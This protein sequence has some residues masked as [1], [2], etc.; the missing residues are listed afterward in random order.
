MS[1]VPTRSRF[2]APSPAVLDIFVIWHPEDVMGA[3]ICDTLF[4]HYHSDF[5]SGL[6]GSAV[7][8]YGRSIPLP[9]AGESP[10]PII[11]TDGVV[12]D[13][14]LAN[15]SQ[16]APFSSILPVIG[17]NLIQASLKE[18]SPWQKYLNS[19]LLLRESTHNNASHVLILPVL[20]TNRLDFS[21]APIITRLMERQGLIEDHVSQLYE[22]THPH[23]PAAHGRL[24]RDLNQAVIQ[25]LLHEPGEPDRFTIFV[26]HSRTE[27]S[28]ADNVDIFPLGPVAKIQALAAK[29]RLSTFIDVH[30]LQ[31]GKDWDEEIRKR[32]RQSAL[33]MVRTDL[34]S[35]REW[36]QWEVLEAKKAGMPVVC[37]NSLTLGEQRGSFLMDHV[38]TVAYPAPP[39]SANSR[40]SSTEECIDGRTSVD[41]REQEAIVVALNRLVDESLKR[42]L[43]RHQD[44]PRDVDR[45][46]GSSR[47]VSSSNTT[48]ID[49]F[50][51]APVHAPEP[52]ML[53]RFLTDHKKKFPGDTH[54]W[55]IHP[56]P[57]LLPPEHEIMVDLCELSGYERNHIHLL[58][59]RTFF[60]AGGIYGAGEPT[61]STPN[62]ILQRPLGDQMLGISMALCEDLQ[63]I[64]LQNKHLE[65]A[66]AEVAQMV[67]LAGGGITYAGAIGTHAPDL[68]NAVIGTVQRY[69]ETAKLTQHRQC[70]THVDKMRQ[71][72][73]GQMFK[74]TVP[75]TSI[76][77]QENINRLKKTAREF[78]STGKIGVLTETGDLRNLADAK[79]WVTPEATARAL[80]EIRKMLPTHCTARLVIGGK[81]I[82]ASTTASNGYLGN[83]PGIIEEA[84]YSV[85]AGQ[86]LFIAGG[87]GGAAAILAHELGLGDRIPVFLESVAA[88]NSHPIY[89]TAMDEIKERYDRS[90]TGLDDEELARLTTTQRASELA[91]LV[92]RGLSTY[93]SPDL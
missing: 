58:T 78:A 54:L 66:I 34:Y 89:R 13:E 5:F 86:P 21:N 10:P 37:L 75:C 4:E 12:G 19:L 25:D 65:L 41:R 26:S 1:P 60:A 82:P 29:T 69:I 80:T 84:L 20:P 16:P 9:G 85:R 40:K 72:H 23:S 76:R 27:I 32:A 45:R 83:Y 48:N 74:L 11:T 2:S 63:A 14:S 88:I 93:H 17:E 67:L 52:L 70:G 3:T 59:P 36:T 91:G 71:L 7:E 77:T 31:A 35:S 68:T 64:G 73:P 62:L 56:D 44:I 6:A 51:A 30:D 42:S 18:N 49:G 61:L 24:T 22:P 55:L 90:L 33:L 87:F 8:V 81:T 38:P 43:W 57:P 28:D 79:L 47:E 15:Q 53:T 50:D 46:L 92:V 39:R